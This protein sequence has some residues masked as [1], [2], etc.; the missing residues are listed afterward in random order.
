MPFHLLI[1]KLQ[2]LCTVL[3]IPAYNLKKRPI[4]IYNK[5]FN[6]LKVIDSIF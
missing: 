3:K 4:D 1:F 5:K 6:K 2:K